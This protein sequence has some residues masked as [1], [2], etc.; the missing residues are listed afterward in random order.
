MKK[1]LKPGGIVCS[2]GGCYFTELTQVGE[3]LGYCRAQFP[4][5][6][7]ATICVPTY[8]S[9]QIGFIVGSLNADDKLNEPKTVFSAEEIDRLQLKCYT[10]DSHRGAFALPRFAEKVLY[11]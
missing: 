5:S 8:P 7:F 4:V 6:G 10:S 9:G 3:T 11:R 2:Q 1:A